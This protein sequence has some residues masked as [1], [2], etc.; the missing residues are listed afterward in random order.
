MEEEE[1]EG[2][3]VGGTVGMEVI[4]LRMVTSVRTSALIN[5]PF[6]KTELG[7]KHEKK[8]GGDERG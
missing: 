7:V 5:V 2:E 4:I 3:G 6:S 1:G 8:R